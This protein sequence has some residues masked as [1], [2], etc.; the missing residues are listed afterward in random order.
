MKQLIFISLVTIGFITASQVCGCGSCES[1]AAT[2]NEFG[3]AIGG[4]KTVTLKITGMTCSGCA[5]HVSIALSKVEGI[6]SEDV[7]YP[8]DRNTITYDPDKTSEQDIIAAIEKTGYRAQVIA[9]KS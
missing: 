9:D 6:I 2:P 8:G 5:N 4:E 3:Y 1:K 7:S